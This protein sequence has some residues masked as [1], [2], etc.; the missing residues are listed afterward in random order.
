[1]KKIV[2]FFF[3]ALSAICVQAQ[4]EQY[5]SG[6]WMDM[7]YEL[8]GSNGVL[9]D[10]TSSFSQSYIVSNTNNALVLLFTAKGRYIHEYKIILPASVYDK[11]DSPEI[12]NEHKAKI[13]KCEIII[14]NEIDAFKDIEM[15]YI[16]FKDG[17]LASGVL[18]DKDY[19]FLEQRVHIFLA[20]QKGEDIFFK[21][22]NGNIF[23]RIKSENFWNKSNMKEKK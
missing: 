1:M 12:G 22:E 6:Y 4:K 13:A 18:W 21:M 16:F 19:D 15:P 3:F 23:V 14:P 11:I 2:L 5:Q 7:E 17:E 9:K 10:D 20:L 8:Y